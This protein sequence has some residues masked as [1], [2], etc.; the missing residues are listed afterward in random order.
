M[1]NFFKQYS[2]ENRS[3]YPREWRLFSKKKL[4]QNITGRTG[5]TPEEPDPSA[6]PVNQMIMK[7][8]I[9]LEQHRIGP[10]A[11]S[12]YQGDADK[13]RHILEALK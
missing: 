1:V 7:N 4:I 2:L 9:A 10:R 12:A 8:V 5:R 6:N 11:G 3:I 13:E